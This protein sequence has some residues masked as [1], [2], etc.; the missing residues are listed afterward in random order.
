[1]VSSAATKAQQPTRT[2]APTDQPCC[3][4]WA[5]VLRVWLCKL[6]VRRE[7]H[8]HGYAGQRAL[9][10]QRLLACVMR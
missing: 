4:G 9:L 6:R 1:M 8:A 3:F 5:R 2:A 10:G 7:K